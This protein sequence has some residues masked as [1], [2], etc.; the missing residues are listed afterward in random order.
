DVGGESRKAIER[1]V[2]AVVAHRLARPMTVLVGDQRIP[3]R[4]SD[5]V[6]V[7]DHATAAAAL[8]VGQESFGARAEALMSPFSGHHDIE[9]ILQIRRIAATKYLPTLRRFGRAPVD[10]KVRLD[11]TKPV[12]TA[13]RAG[14]TP[15][16]HA[17]LQ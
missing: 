6:T 13:A 4:P 1:D 14:T 10:A 12:V 9:P 17:P 7:N 2:R 11:G 3:V 15:D 5:L 16:A 8:R